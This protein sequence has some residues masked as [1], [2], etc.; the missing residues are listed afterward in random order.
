M[1]THRCRQTR[2][3]SIGSCPA[4]DELVEESGGATALDQ[5]LPLCLPFRASN[6]A[7]PEIALMYQT[8]LPACPEE[9]RALL[10]AIVLKPV[11]FSGSVDTFFTSMTWESSVEPGSMMI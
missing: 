3:G 8:A 2:T 11:T 5:W 4:N 10:L 6:K 7:S 9:E 1:P